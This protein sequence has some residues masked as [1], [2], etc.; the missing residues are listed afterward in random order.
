M[1]KVA[2]AI[3]LS[4]ISQSCDVTF[5]N[6]VSGRYVAFQGA[7]EVVGPCLN[8]IPFR[9]RIDTNQC[10]GSL[11][12]DA[13]HQG[14]DAIPFEATPF[15]RIA[16]QSPWP[17]ATGFH[18][19]FQYQNIPGREDEDQILPGSGWRRLGSAV[20]GGGLLQSGACWL[21]AWPSVRG[22][23]RFLS[24]YSEETM[25]TSEAGAV[26]D[27]FVGRL[28]LINNDP[29]AGV[30]SVSRLYPAAKTIQSH[31]LV[32]LQPGQPSSSSSQSRPPA[33]ALTPIMDEFASIWKCVLGFDGEI[34]P[35][36]SFFDM[37]GDS[38][39]AARM[40]SAC[41]KMG[42]GLSVQDIID[43]PTLMSQVYFVTGRAESARK[44]REAVNLV[45]ED[46]YEF[47]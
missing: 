28:R 14:I 43:C 26:M 34:H 11:A 10:F 16:A 32:P 22:T 5:G 3:T 30:A 37:G 13:Y 23:A 17:S 35:H 44:H 6:L 45:Y 8:V 18:S 2:W 36:D 38:I 42:L 12:K 4:Q 47:I 15:N 41:A 7:Q 1:L 21:T 39:A 46:S 31:C 9:V 29:E 33:T 25:E 24:R 20:Y 27:L 40:A 19:M